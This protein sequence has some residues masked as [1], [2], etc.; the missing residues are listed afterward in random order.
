[1]AYLYRH[2]RLDKNE[3]FYIG[4][5][6]N[7]NYKRAYDTY[8]RN[9]IWKDIVSKSLYEVEILLDDLTWEEVCIKEIEFIKLYG[10]KDLGNGT[11]SNL[12][13]GGEGYLNPSNETRLKIS[14]SKQG[15]NNPM[16]GKKISQIHKNKI[17]NSNLGRVFSIETRNKIS[18]SQ[19]G[20]PRNSEEN[21]KYLS[22]INSGSNH[23]QYG[24][25][26]SES[27]KEKISKS[28]LGGKN[29]GARKVIDTKTNKIYSCVLECLEDFNIN[30]ETLTA[31][32]KGRILNNTTL[33]YLEYAN[34]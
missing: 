6:S 14:N 3:P 9:K 25:T 13:D 22:K 27:T 18:N 16:Y 29:P 17:A 34:L 8:K 28:R 30:Y 11:L 5:G 12:T 7:N 20:I 2:I 23:P 33:K 21:K 15:C 19:K 31:K 4:I 24:K 32:L 26:K 1:M 10:R